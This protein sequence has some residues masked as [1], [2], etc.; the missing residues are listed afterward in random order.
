MTQKITMEKRRSYFLNDGI[1]INDRNLIIYIKL[2]VLKCNMNLFD[3]S[4]D[5]RADVPG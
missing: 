4:I 3:T 5:P 2:H 1:I